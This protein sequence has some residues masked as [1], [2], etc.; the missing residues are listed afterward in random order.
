MRA[1][2]VHSWTRGA[3]GRLLASSA[4]LWVTVCGALVCSGTANAQAVVDGSDG[5]PRLAPIARGN[6]SRIAVEGGRVVQF[7]YDEAELTVEKDE[8]NG[9]LFVQPKVDRPVSVFVVTERNTHALVLE[10]KD[11]PVATVFVREAK[12]ADTRP[13]AKVQIERAGS[14]DAAIKRLVT[15]MARGE[16]S[17]EFQIVEI[18]KPIALWT[19]SSFHFVRRFDGR[20]LIGEEYRLT[21]VS[22]T[23]MRV[24]EQ[25]LFKD[26][27]IAVSVELHE[28]AP[29]AS[30]AVFVVR[31]NN[32]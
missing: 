6:K 25:E 24:A 4:A 18:G 9:Q 14:L 28:L 15:V 30:T 21:N 8:A 31:I 16:A 10:P 32:G 13:E 27:V 12:H 1:T 17:P 3:V 26:G 5:K 2:H 23:T 19:E 11:V 20:T 29:G 22:G 7:V